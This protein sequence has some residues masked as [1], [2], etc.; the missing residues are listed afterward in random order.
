MLDA[1]VYPAQEDIWKKSVS[2]NFFLFFNFFSEMFCETNLNHEK[3]S[4]N[5]T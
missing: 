1:T 4:G 5:V 2:G 3:F